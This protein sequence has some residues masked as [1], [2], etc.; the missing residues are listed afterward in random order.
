MKF[1]KLS[2]AIININKISSIQIY[3]DKYYIN[4][5]NNTF[6]GSFIGF[7]GTISSTKDQIQIC[8]QQN[9]EDYQTVTNWI[10]KLEL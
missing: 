5:V 6:G 10:N 7:F 4:L 2:S 1:L 9:T 8:K 3:N